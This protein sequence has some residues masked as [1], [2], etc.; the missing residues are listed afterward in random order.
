VANKELGTQALWLC[1]TFMRAGFY[2]GG[3]SGIFVVHFGIFK[4][5]NIYVVT[6][7]KITT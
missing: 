3:F 2:W 4:F 5:P 7:L 1:R 6:K